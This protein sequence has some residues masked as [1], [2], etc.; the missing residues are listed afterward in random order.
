MLINKEELHVLTEPVLPV[1]IF[2]GRS[3]E[4]FSMNCFNLEN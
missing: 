4:E 1:P 3:D 2:F